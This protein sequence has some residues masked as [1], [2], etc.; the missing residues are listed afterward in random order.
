MNIRPM[1]DVS[2]MR[3]S[4]TRLCSLSKRARILRKYRTMLVGIDG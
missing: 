2:S 3:K 1:I 4:R